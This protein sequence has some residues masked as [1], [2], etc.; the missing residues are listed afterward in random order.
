ML[1][2]AGF[3]VLSSAPQG[4]YLRLG[5]F[6]TRIGGFSPLLG[7]LL[8]GLFRMLHLRQIPIPLNFG[9]LFTAYAIKP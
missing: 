4:R 6:A 7:R 1:A 8:G 5:Y 9:D 2:Q 3:K